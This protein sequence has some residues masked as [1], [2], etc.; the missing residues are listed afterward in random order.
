M[1]LYPGDNLAVAS[2]PIA[3]NQDRPHPLEARAM[4]RCDSL[5][6]L[7]LMAQDE[8]GEWLPQGDF[9]GDDMEDDPAFYDMGT[10]GAGDSGWQMV[11]KYFSPRKPVKSVR[12]F[13]CAR[14]AEL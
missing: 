6:G 13:L 4:V 7:E 9:L 11:R 3:L 12:L 10:T 5:R 2:A 14:G 1:T 8:S